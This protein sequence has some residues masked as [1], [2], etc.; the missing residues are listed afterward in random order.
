[1][2]TAQGFALLP[3]TLLVVTGSACGLAGL[4]LNQVQGS[5]QVIDDPRQV[6]AFTE[7]ASFGSTDIEITIGQPAQVIVHADD[8]IAPLI[9][10]TVTGE[11]LRIENRGNF[12]TRSAVSVRITVPKLNGLDLSGSGEAS[13]TGLA[14]EQFEIALSGSGDITAQGTTDSLAISV[15]GSGNVAAG[16]LAARVASV[17]VTGSGD[18]EVTASEQLS[19]SVMGSGDIT[20]GGDPKSLDRQVMGSGEISP[21][22]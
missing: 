15:A 21:R 19:A 5:G 20:Y 17:N 13:I 9:A 22:R 4:A 14:A 3:I 11:T 16:K 6:A 10:T 2:R 1:M 12:S 8:N 18:V 7:V